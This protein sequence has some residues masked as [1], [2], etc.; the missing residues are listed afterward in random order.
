V[1]APSDAHG[2]Y[3]VRAETLEGVDLQQLARTA[4]ERDGQPSAS[5]GLL[6]SLSGPERVIRL[7]YDGPHTYG[8][9]GA[10]WYRD[11][12]ALAAA[13][14]G[15]LPVTVHAYSFDPDSFEGVSTYGGGARVGGET[16]VYDELDLDLEEL[17]EPE[18]ERVRESWPL[19]RLARLLG[20]RRGQLLPLDGP[21]FDLGPL[22]TKAPGS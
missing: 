14:S 12:H 7:A 4:L 10:T 15:A 5:A 1:S 22:W 19:G 11:H 2:G 18:F 3:L 21:P 17:S 9:S 20:M 16:V 13:L 8:R 6:V